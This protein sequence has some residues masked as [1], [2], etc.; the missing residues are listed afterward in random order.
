MSEN[1]Q[2]IS[3]QFFWHVTLKFFQVCPKFVRKRLKTLT[4]TQ[5]YDFI[6]ILLQMWF[7][8]VVIFYAIIP[9]FQNSAIS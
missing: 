5:W 9:K 7:P 3:N 8:T 4:K 6:G 1:S 2:M